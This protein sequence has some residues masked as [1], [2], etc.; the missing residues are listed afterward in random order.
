MEIGP[1]RALPRTNEG[2]LRN[3]DGRHAQPLV[4]KDRGVQAVTASEL[5]DPIPPGPRLNEGQPSHEP[6]VAG[7]NAYCTSMGGCRQAPEE[8]RDNMPFESQWFSHPLQA[9]PLT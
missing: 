5:Q 1:R 7:G 4:D 6:A 8:S 3:V 2:G 9:W